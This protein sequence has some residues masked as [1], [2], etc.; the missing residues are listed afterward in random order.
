MPLTRLDGAKIRTCWR[1]RTRGPRRARGAGELSEMAR[2]DCKAEIDRCAPEHGGGSRGSTS[3][4]NRARRVRVRRRH[5]VPRRFVRLYPEY[6][7]GYL[8]PPPPRTP[9]FSVACA[10]GAR[11]RGDVAGDALRP[12]RSPRRRARLPSCLTDSKR[13][14]IVA[15][16]GFSS[17]RTALTHWY[18]SRSDAPRTWRRG[19]LARLERIRHR[20]QLLHRHVLEV[21][22]GGL[23]RGCCWCFVPAASHP[24]AGTA[25]ATELAQS[26]PGR[27]GSAASA[28]ADD[29]DG[30]RF[31][32]DAAQAPHRLEE[33]RAPR[34]VER[35]RR[36]GT[37][38]SAARRGVFAP[39]S[40]TRSPGGQH[41]QLCELRAFGPE[42]HG[43]SSSL[44]GAP[45]SIAPAAS[46]ANSAS[47][48]CITP[49]AGRPAGRAL[50]CA[51]PGRARTSDI[52]MSSHVSHSHA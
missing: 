4:G 22:A 21:P 43:G 32:P 11:R 36:R 25:R 14:S 50:C 39:G 49:R 18:R 19:C 51:G 47:W 13:A 31:N 42:G 20:H 41:A 30:A 5:H 40:R 26:G 48:R 17:P 6:K 23:T 27:R 46:R 45:R 2:L 35:R 33:R 9:N 52:W 24:C 16:N 8:P 28:A 34:A 29:D 7:Y 38:S 15:L 37:V 44:S 12:P 10:E 1:P 3:S